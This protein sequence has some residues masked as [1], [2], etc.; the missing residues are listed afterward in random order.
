LLALFVCLQLRSSTSE[1]SVRLLLKPL[2]P[3]NAKTGVTACQKFSTWWHLVHRIGKHDVDWKSVLGPFFVYCFGRSK[4][5]ELAVGKQ[6]EVLHIP[7]AKALAYVLDPEP[8][9]QCASKKRK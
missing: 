4:S 7:C 6:Y 8:T 3:N 5:E 1:R 9:K 2:L